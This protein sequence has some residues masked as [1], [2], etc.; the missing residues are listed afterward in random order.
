MGKQG[1]SGCTTL[2]TL[3]LDARLWNESTEHG[4]NR[5]EILSHIA[6][7]TTDAAR[8]LP[9]SFTYLNIVVSPTVSEWVIP[10]TGVMGITY[11]DEYIS[12]TFDAAIPY[13]LDSLRRALRST[14]FHEMVHATTFV[15][16]PWQSSA[17]FGTVT[18]GL[19]TVFERD[20][21]GEAKPLWGNYEDDT[22]MS[23]W[24]QEIK[25]LPR[26]EQ[27][28]RNYF[29]AHNDG[30]KWIVYKTGVWIVD[31]LLASGEDLFAL[32]KLSHADVIEKFEAL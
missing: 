32:M 11:N 15:H 5:D 3:T 25:L 30:R 16:D 18:E 23:K 28:D 10:E 17:L 27:K 4:V 9:S 6:N 1:S 8:L 31:K 7:A 22:T 14:T 24:Y 26:T 12:L 2:N 29:V 19:A 21:S 20:Y 13:G